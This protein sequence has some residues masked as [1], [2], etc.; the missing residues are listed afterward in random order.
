MPPTRPMPALLTRMSR[1]GDV[2]RRRRRWRTAAG[3]VH[4]DGGGA[5]QLGGERLGACEVDVGQQDVGAGA[6][7]FAGGGG[8][9]AAGG[10]GDKGDLVFQVKDIS[11]RLKCHAILEKDTAFG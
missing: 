6:G 11:H 3:D 4:R 7:E 10:A 9:D 2:L 5:G 1:C 8:A